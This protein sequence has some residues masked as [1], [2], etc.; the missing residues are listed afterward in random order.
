MNCLF[1]I[2][3]ISDDGKRSLS[4]GKYFSNKKKEKNWK[5]FKLSSKQVNKYLFKINKIIRFQL[6][7]TFAKTFITLAIMMIMD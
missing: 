5:D 2:I 4:L 7:N 6:F 3:Q 1:P